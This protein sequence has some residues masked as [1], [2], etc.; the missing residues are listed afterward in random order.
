MLVGILYGDENY[1][2]PR[3]RRNT[4]SFGGRGVVPS[5]YALGSDE[6]LGKSSLLGKIVRAP[7]K[8]GSKVVRTTYKA[9][10]TPVRQ[11]SHFGA[12]IVRGVGGSTAGTVRSV[13]RS[14]AA[15]SPGIA[16][17]LAAVYGGQIPQMP[18]FTPPLNAP[19]SGIPATAEDIVNQ[20][21]SNTALT[22]GLAGGGAL[23]LGLAIFA[24]TRRK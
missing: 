1:T 18:G 24:L 3:R 2:A 17:G 15:A 6:L 22:Y 14:A 5:G 12:N 11:V 8:L 13:G 16:A 10:A 23:L 20:N 4:Y 7:G 9:V 21:K 19:G